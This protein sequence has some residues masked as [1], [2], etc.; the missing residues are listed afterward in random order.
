MMTSLRSFALD[1][2]S[3]NTHEG[4]QHFFN[5]EA[6]ETGQFR[7]ILISPGGG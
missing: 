1:A 2:S 6:I 4:A 3:E 7:P 5:F